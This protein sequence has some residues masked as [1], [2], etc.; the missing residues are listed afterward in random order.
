MASVTTT[1]AVPTTGAIA[2][3]LGEP[4]HR[5][6]YVIRSR[7]IRPAHRAGHVRIFTEADVATVREELRRIDARRQGESN[8]GGGGSRSGADHR[9]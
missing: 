8:D 9:G 2:Q 4:L 1:S 3:R 5:V 7:H 6:E